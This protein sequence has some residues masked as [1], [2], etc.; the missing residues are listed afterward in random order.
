MIF[1]LSYFLIEAYRPMVKFTEM[2]AVDHFRAH[3]TIARRQ[4]PPRH[5]SNQ[6]SFARVDDHR[7][8]QSE[9]TTAC[10]RY[11]PFSSIKFQTVARLIKKRFPLVEI[12]TPL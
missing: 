11:S 6:Y 7:A 2:C 5:G 10:P 9:K 12:R 8:S 3:A 4:G 1:R